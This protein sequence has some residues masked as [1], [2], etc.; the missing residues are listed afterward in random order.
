M[1]KVIKREVKM[2]R[3]KLSIT[4]CSFIVLISVSLS[5]IVVSATESAGG[6]VNT[7]GEISFYEEEFVPE[8]SAP[9]EVD[10]PG[11]STKPEADKD[12]KPAGM[13]PDTGELLS[14]IGLIGLVLLL[15][16]IGFVWKKRRRRN[17]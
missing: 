3:T 8:E 15:I 16:W 1:M 6:Q 9:V 10:E 2:S 11:T 12:A 14:Y 17:K 13:L 4:L 5:P 7:G